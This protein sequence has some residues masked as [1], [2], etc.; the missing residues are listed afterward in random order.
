MALLL[1]YPILTLPSRVRGGGT[2]WEHGQE[3]VMLPGCPGW[4]RDLDW[5]VPVS[6]QVGKCLLLWRAAGSKAQSFSVLLDGLTCPSWPGHPLSP[7]QIPVTTPCL[8]PPPPSL[9]PYPEMPEMSHVQTGCHARVAGIPWRCRRQL[10]LLSPGQQAG[11]DCPLQPPQA[12]ACLHTHVCVTS[13]CCSP[14]KFKPRVKFIVSISFILSIVLHFI[15]CCDILNGACHSI[16]TTARGY[17]HLLCQA[18]RQP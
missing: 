18:F 3:L 2:S 16:L 4:R 6:I 9:H 5:L 7:W 14:R 10:S 13:L 8:P 1:L 12:H 17:S 15:I 11:G